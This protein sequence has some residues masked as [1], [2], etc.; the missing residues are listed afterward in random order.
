M[1][2][3]A[4]IAAENIVL[5]ERLCCYRPKFSQR[6]GV[7][8]IKIV[9]D[10]LDRSFMSHNSCLFADLHSAGDLCRWPFLHCDSGCEP[11]LFLP[12]GAIPAAA[13]KTWRRRR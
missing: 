10:Q 13:K 5:P 11:R 12:E 2:A 6:R 1:F 3:K 7:D 4:A 8:A 9:R